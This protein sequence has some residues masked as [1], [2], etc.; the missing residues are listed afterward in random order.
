[1]DYRQEMQE[2]RQQLNHHGYLYYVLD[3]P[4]IPDY[5]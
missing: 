5:E 2:L 3:A 1:M 4:E